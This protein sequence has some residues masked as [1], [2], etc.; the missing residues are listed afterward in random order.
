VIAT[1]PR[2]ISSGT[3]LRVG[4]LVCRIDFKEGA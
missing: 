2:L 1:E 4:T 3:I